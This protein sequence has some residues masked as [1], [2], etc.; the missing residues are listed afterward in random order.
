VGADPL[1][2][3]C[4]ATSDN[5]TATWATALSGQTAVSGSCNA[6]YQPT[7][8]PPVRDCNLDGSWGPVSSPCQRTC[9]CATLVARRKLLTSCAGHAW[10]RAFVRW[11]DRELCHLPV[12]ACGRAASSRHMCRRLLWQR[13]A[14]LPQHGP[15]GPD[16]RL[17]RWYGPVT[18]HDEKS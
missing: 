11:D 3:T 12:V 8:G 15:V 1:G 7:A 6:G 18:V 10:Y 4:L 13:V 16:H 5:P 14:R 2:I 9:A 17:V